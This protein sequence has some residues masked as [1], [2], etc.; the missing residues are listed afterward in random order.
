MPRAKI[1]RKSTSIDMT[2]MCDVAFLLL[3]FFILATKTKPPEAVAVVT[4]SSVSTKIAKDEAIVVTFD[5]Q[6]KVFLMLGDKAHKDAIIDDI[7][8]TKALGLTPAEL[9]K[10]KKA[11]FIG[12]P[13]SKLKGTLALSETLP[14]NRMDGIPTLDSTNN[15]LTDWIRSVTNAYKGESLEKLNLLVKGDNAAKYPSFKSV[16]ESFKKNEI[17]KFKVVTNSEGIPADSELALNPPKK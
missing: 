14:A 11:E 1:P 4:P 3:S 8:T 7:N 17:F 2:A 15:E 16:K 6:G 12:M 10:L 5:K 13:F 9:A